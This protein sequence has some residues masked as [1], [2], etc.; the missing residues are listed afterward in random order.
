MLI[1]TQ[2]K[3]TKPY[4]DLKNMIKKN[5]IVLKQTIISS[6]AGKSLARA[7]GLSIYFPTHHIDRSYIQ[8]EFAECSKW[9]SLVKE[10]LPGTN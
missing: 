1:T 6:T 7:Q 3:N 2:S 8:T 4:Q 5:I 9:T 10:I